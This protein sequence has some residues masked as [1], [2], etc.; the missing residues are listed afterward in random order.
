VPSIVRSVAHSELLALRQQT[1]FLWDTYFSSV[2]KIVSSTLEII[3]DRVLQHLSRDQ[4]M[5]NTLPGSPWLLREFSDNLAAFPFFYN[6]LGREVGEKFT[7]VIYAT[8]PVTLSSSPLFRLIRTIAKSAYI[9]KMIVIWHCDVAPPPSHRWPADLGV[10]VVVKTRNIKTISSRFYPYQEIETDAV[11]G[12]DEDV[13]LTTD[14][15]IVG[16]PARSHHWDEAKNRWSYSSR[17]SNEYSM[18]LTGASIYHRYYNFLYTNGLGTMLTRSVDD[19]QNCEDILMNFLVSH[20]TKLPPIKVT[21]RKLYREVLLPNNSKNNLW[22]DS[23]HFSQRQICIETFANEFGYM[24][25]IRSKLR[26]DPILFK[27]PVSNLRKKY[28][29]IE[30]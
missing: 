4:V 7:A 21:H 3:K 13:I 20:V 8:T 29:Q 23:F 17:W 25:L 2:D 24:P 9:H 14:E 6:Q 10:P 19:T 26:M 1:Q 15:R 5:W 30:L 16:Y 22:S 28:K 18:V 11:F 27:D 12:F